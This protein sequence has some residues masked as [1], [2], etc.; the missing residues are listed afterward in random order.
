MTKALCRARL[1]PLRS[2]RS[3]AWQRFRVGLLREGQMGR[4]EP[5]VGP[6]EA[7]ELKDVAPDWAGP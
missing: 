6:F 1:R 7:I 4:V 3:A 2:G 5:Q